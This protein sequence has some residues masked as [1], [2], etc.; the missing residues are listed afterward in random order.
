M[1]WNTWSRDHP[2]MHD[3]L[4]ILNEVVVYLFHW[5]LHSLFILLFCYVFFMKKKSKTY[6]SYV[7]LDRAIFF[8][9]L[10]DN[11]TFKYKMRS[12]TNT[13]INCFFFWYDSRFSFQLIW[14][15]ILYSIRHFFSSRKNY[16]SI[17]N[18]FRLRLNVIAN[19]IWSSPI[20]KSNNQRLLPLL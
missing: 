8:I 10:L 14:E 4:F 19:K 15:A 2:M 6:Y 1:C 9:L 13:K 7:W 3:F 5:C 17:I 11:Q 12:H 18:C 16:Y 20:A